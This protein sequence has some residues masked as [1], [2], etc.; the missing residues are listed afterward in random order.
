MSLW[1][2]AAALSV[3]APDL[4]FMRGEWVSCSP[5][6]RVEEHWVDGGPVGLV[7]LGVTRRGERGAFEHLRI[8]PYEGGWAY[9]ASPG[10]RPATAFRLVAADGRSAMF[11]NPGHD[12]PKR[13]AYRLEG[14]AL[15]AST[16][17]LDGKGPSWTFRPRADG[18]C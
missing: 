8:A 17:D 10:G 15:T 12:F 13:I 1:V 11:E 6:E 2:I 18:P 16:T 9:L 3:G 14:R 7:G 5:T 4:A